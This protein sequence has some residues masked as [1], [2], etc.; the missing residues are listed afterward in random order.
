MRV[1]RYAVRKNPV[2]YRTQTSHFTRR[3]FHSET[4]KKRDILV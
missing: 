4:H 3:K 1:K 2:I